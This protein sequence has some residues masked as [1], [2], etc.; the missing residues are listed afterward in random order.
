M[1]KPKQHYAITFAVILT[2]CL[3]GCTA[4]KACGFRGCDGDAKITA[5]IQTSIDQRPELGPNLVGVQTMD[6]V[7]YLYGLVD[8]YWQRQL[9]ESV[10]LDTPGTA[11][12]VNS[13][14]INNRG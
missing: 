11:R 7:V 9:A 6:H 5:N 12:V 14:A 4:Y 3:A 1:D 8:T 10:A 13:I 2:S